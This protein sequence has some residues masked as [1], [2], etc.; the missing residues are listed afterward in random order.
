MWRKGTCLKGYPVDTTALSTTW[1]D[2]LKR[3]KFQL[4]RASWAT[5]EVKGWQ[6]YGGPDYKFLGFVG[7]M[8]SPV[9]VDILH[10]FFF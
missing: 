1:P 7:H 9:S 8:L 2:F 3:Y 5:H 10:F 4:R 6:T